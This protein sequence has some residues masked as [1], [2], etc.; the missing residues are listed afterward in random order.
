MK[1]DSILYIFILSNIYLFL[2]KDHNFTSLKV[3]KL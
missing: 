2:R 1:K 3:E